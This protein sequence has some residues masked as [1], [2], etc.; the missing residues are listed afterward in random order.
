MVFI[1]LPIS[2]LQGLVWFTDF[3]TRER[4][5]VPFLCLISTNSENTFPR[6]GK[7]WGKTIPPKTHGT[8]F[9]I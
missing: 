3:N 9:P 6:D 2:S 7:V 5:V 4:K 8:D 1:R